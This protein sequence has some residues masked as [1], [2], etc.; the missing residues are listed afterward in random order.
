MGPSKEVKTM[1]NVLE[2]KNLSKTYGGLGNA[3]RALD[4]VSFTVGKGEF[5]GVMGASG[6][7]SSTGSSAQPHRASS[8]AASAPAA[9]RR[10]G[11]GMSSHPDV[12]SVKPFYRL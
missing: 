3:T 12:S 7:C 9:A 5:V 10:N 1:E 11:L 8:S 6:S 2:V 4:D